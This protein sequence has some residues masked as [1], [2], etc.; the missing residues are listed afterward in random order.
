MRT[1]YN[2]KGTPDRIAIIL[3][4]FLIY[5]AA[6]FFA[7]AGVLWVIN[8]ALDLSFWNWKVSFGIWL[9]LVLLTANLGVE[10]E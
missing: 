4:I 10:I 7:V 6:S 3:A 1:K 8:W 2:V 5:L 9:A